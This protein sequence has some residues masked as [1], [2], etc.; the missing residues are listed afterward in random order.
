MNIADKWQD[1][2]LIDS[3]D[4]EK[5]EKW[6]NVT[7]RRPDPEAIWAQSSLPLWNQADYTYTRSVTGG[8]AWDKPADFSW[9]VS[10]RDLK[11]KVGLMGFKHMGL[12]PEQA[13][14]WD[15]IMAK[16]KA[17]NRT[18]IKVLNLFAYTG[19]ATIASSF[20]G[21][22]EVVH[23]DASKGMISWANDNVKLNGLENHTIRFICDDCLKFVKREIKRGHH[24]DC[25]IMDPPSFG[26][27]SSGE[28]WKFDHDIQNLITECTQ[29]L[30]PNPL[31]MLVNSYTTG[32]SSQAVANILTTTLPQGQVTCG[33]LGL[34]AQSNQLVLP[35]GIYAR[36]EK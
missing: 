7:V 25:I 15:Y 8:G 30:T 2:T 31:F 24:Y 27:G 32:I 34:I 21:A 11:F 4:G 6:G 14:N 12:F 35:C 13:Y 22:A 18:D 17:S 28:V 3:G 19:G 16:I 23:V 1:Y 9:T 36:W 5:L 33:E 29:L 10:Y 26:R 20:A